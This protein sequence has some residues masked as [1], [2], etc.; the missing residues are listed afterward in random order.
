MSD[1]ITPLTPEQVAL[2][3]GQT[4]REGY[5]HRDIVEVDIAANVI[6]LKGQPDETISSHAARA[7]EEGHRWGRWVSGFLNLFQP[8]HGIKAQA[9][10]TQ[11]AEN[12]IQ[13]EK[14]ELDK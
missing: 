9:G 1:P 7:D 4:A 6:L 5:L 14:K 10:D 8:D 2:Q 11:R 3:E 12:V 13:L